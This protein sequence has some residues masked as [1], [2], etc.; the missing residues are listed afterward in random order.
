ME[1]DKHMF[2]FL[3]IFKFSFFFVIASHLMSIDNIFYGLLLYNNR[4]C[5]HQ[6]AYD[7][8]KLWKIAKV[9]CTASSNKIIGEAHAIVS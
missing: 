1:I 9:E 5:D 8:M 2:F 6:Q 4:F 3:K 7:H